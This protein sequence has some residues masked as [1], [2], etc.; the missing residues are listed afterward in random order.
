MWTTQGVSGYL[1]MD[2]PCE[3]ELITF[4]GGEPHVSYI[5]GLED[6]Q[7]VTI[8]ARITDFNGVG[9]M[10]V[11]VDYIRRTAPGVP[12]RAYIPYLPGARQDRGAPL[13]ARVYADLI[14]SCEFQEVIS[15]DPHSDVMPALLNNFRGVTQDK[16]FELFVPHVPG[17]GRAVL[18]TP[19]V[20]ATKKTEAIA[21]KYGYQVV[22]GQKHR[23]F[24][25]GKLSGFSCAPIPPDMNV[26]IVDDICDGGGTFNGLA[27]AIGYHYTNM[28]LVVT[29]GIFSK[30]MFDLSERFGKIM[31]TDSFCPS[32]NSNVI[33]I[34]YPK[35]K[36]LLE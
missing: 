36:E 33:Q 10:L 1:Q 26:I 14:N 13:T 31:Y 4:P 16:L 34:D 22:I 18:V 25:T 6:S 17:P 29:H 20:G 35:V 11:V 23:D 27:D 8:E 19:D 15:L 7:Y 5:S 2:F 9:Q 30:G 32:Y 12:I 24:K 28:W 21:A 3:V